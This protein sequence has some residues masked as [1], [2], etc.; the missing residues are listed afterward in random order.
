MKLIGKIEGRDEP[1][2]IE[3]DERDGRVTASIDGREYELEV[4]RPE[5]GVFTFRSSDGRI[6]NAVV[7]PAADGRRHVR[8]GGDEY[9][10]ELTDPKRLRTKGAGSGA[11]A[12]T[13]EIKTAMPGK[14]VRVL[15]EPGAVVEH[16]QPVIVVEAMKMQNEMKSPKDGTVRSVNAAEGDTVNAGAVLV[17]ID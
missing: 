6:F 2:N 14:V 12:G 3:L 16:G 7:S 10:I 13:A 1:N 5:P 9:I 11:D 8:V 15:V 4:S 17:V